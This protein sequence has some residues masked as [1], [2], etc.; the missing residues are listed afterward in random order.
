M[1]N[2]KNGF[3][4]VELIAVITV[5]AIILV[6]AT[7]SVIGIVT[8]SRKDSFGL[9]VKNIGKTI[10]H[11]M[12]EDTA[13]VCDGRKYDIQILEMSNLKRLTGTW[14]CTNKLDE[15]VYSFTV[16]DGEFYVQLTSGQLNDDDFVIEDYEGPKMK[17]NDL[18][19][20]NYKIGDT[21]SLSVSDVEV[22]NATSTTFSVYENGVLLV[23]DVTE[24]SYDV[25][26]V[27]DFS[28]VYSATNEISDIQMTRTINIQGSNIQE[29]VLDDLVSS[30]DGL[31]EFG[32][33]DHRYVGNITDNYVWYSGYM[34]R[35]VGLDDGNVKLVT[36]ENITTLTY[37]K[38]QWGA[39]IYEDSYAEQWLEKIFLPSLNNYASIAKN[40]VVC[41]DGAS[42][43]TS[44]RT[45]CTN[46]LETNVGLLS[47]D[48]Y[49]FSNGANGYLNNEQ[50][51]YTLTPAQQDYL[52][53]VISETGEVHSQGALGTINYFGYRPTITLNDNTSF[54][55]GD[56]NEENP[57]I[58]G[59]SNQAVQQNNTYVS[60]KNSGEYIE[61]NGNLWR[62]SSIDSQGVKIVL[63]DLYSNEAGETQ[64]FLWGTEVMYTTTSGIGQSLNTDVYND[65]FTESDKTLVNENAKWYIKNY[66][67]AKTAETTPL[68]NPINTL[69]DY[70]NYTIASVGMLNI[71]EI[72]ST[73][74]TDSETSRYWVLSISDYSSNDYNWYLGEKGQGFANS[75]S[76]NVQ[77]SVKPSV[78]LLPSVKVVLGDGTLNNPYKLE[79]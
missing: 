58:L 40:S 28:V 70:S 79:K 11:T 48:E 13:I 64:K 36:D 20:D 9:S 47:L 63:N 57:Y 3:T 65:L 50:L 18:L 6:I 41:L 43:S 1:K 60:N 5:L 31:Y 33:D 8:S 66:T 25:K 21:I 56:G 76:L 69:A 24:Y 34:W 73:Q 49:N 53:Y 27:V 32:E 10:E 55:G 14:S 42:S 62:I 45:S 38:Y 30:G 75:D 17:F 72:L 37:N 44:E 16:T 77:L 23:S 59:V 2:N 35:I 26:K 78:Y 61:I 19:V 7:P 54:I 15:F 4:L 51:F 74:N 39:A 12:L 22:I 29:S 67:D 68:E 71:G 46:K 52:I